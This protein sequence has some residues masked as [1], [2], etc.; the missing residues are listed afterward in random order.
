MKV[1]TVVDRTSLDEGAFKEQAGGF[2]RLNKQFDGKL[3]TFL[4]DLRQAV[5]EGA[6]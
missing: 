4:G 1:E 6:G 2:E 3:E 5:W